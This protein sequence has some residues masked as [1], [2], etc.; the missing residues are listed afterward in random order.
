MTPANV[1]WKVDDERFEIINFEFSD[2]AVLT[3]RIF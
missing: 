2:G 3:K 1:I